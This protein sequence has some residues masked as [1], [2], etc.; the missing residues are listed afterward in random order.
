MSR[1]LDQVAARY[2]AQTALTRGKSAVARR[3]RPHLG[4]VRCRTR[5]GVLIDADPRDLIQYSVMVT[6]EWEPEE[7]E[8]MR[9]QVGPGD[10]VY[11]VGANVGYF[12]LLASRLVG[13]TGRVVAFEPNPTTLSRL[14]H[15]LALN[16]ATNVTVVPVGLADRDGEAEFHSVAGA[17]SGASS[18]RAL[19]DSTVSRIELARLDRLVD[20]LGLRLPD[21]VK[22]DIEGAE[23]V[24]L[25]GMAT[26]LQHAPR[27]Q[28]LVEITDK[29][30]R[31][32][33][34]SEAEL[35]EFL[36]TVGLELVGE[37]SRHVKV[38]EHG[39]PFQYTALFR[40]R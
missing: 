26:T 25:R 22:L 30:L 2:F 39:R 4:V 3:L 20:E 34:G 29:F 36:D 6:G 10:V 13:P 8:V 31:Q 28:L 21:F 17:N 33:S 32:T 23:L 19:D 11:D 7:T 14:R 37:V 40:R 18:L 12:T 27:V 16:D 1:L 5:D 38:D 15:H 24:A 9:R 35:L